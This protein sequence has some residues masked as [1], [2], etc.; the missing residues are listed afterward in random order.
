M[1]NRMKEAGAGDLSVRMDVNTKDEIGHLGNSF[2]QMLGAINQLIANTKDL[3]I[4]ITESAQNLAASA[5]QASAST[6]E[7]SQTIEDIAKGSSEQAIDAEKASMVAI[8]LS[9]K[10]NELEANTNVMITS[11]EEVI[12]ANV[13]GVTAIDEL[14]IKS[15]KSDDANKKIANVITELDEKTQH[16]GM[17]LESISAIAVQTNLLALNASIEA[18]RAGEH[19]KGFA[20]VADEIR[21]LA[22]ESS[23]SA[24]KIRTIVTDIQLDSKKSVESM[25]EV[26][27]IS[28]EQG[29]AVQ[30]V[31]ESFKTISESIRS[32]INKINEMSNSVADINEN[33]NEL[34]HVI[35]NVSA[36]SEETAAASE[37]VNASTVQQA[38][39]V[40]EVA[41]A[42]EIL[43]RISISLDKE[44]NRFKL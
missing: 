33:K 3:S 19:G 14:K 16:I 20:V 13:A 23:D 22:E 25:S 34:S 18:A 32:I 35:S 38:N 36:I 11:S 42:A 28:K 21:K 12:N 2:N 24:E 29:V 9:D 10:I 7:V 17:I 26:S 40:E 41:K 39:V 31:E 5:E 6:D 8:T 15:S 1:T 44:L 4:E 30:N 43:N 37:E 27:S